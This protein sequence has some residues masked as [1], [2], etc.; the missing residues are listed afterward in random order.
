MIYE[1]L[2]AYLKDDVKAEDFAK[3]ATAIFTKW[4]ETEAGKGFLTDEAVKKLYQ[5]EIDR[6][7]SKALETFQAKTMPE[8]IKEAVEA[9]IK[10]LNPEETPEQ[11]RIRELEER[12]KQLEKQ[13]QRERLK[14]YA[15]KLLTEKKLDALTGNIDIFIVGD[16][17]EEVRAK[18]EAVETAIN[19]IVEKA[20][21]E[22]I[23]SYNGSGGNNGSGGGFNIDP[24]EKN[25]YK[26]GES[27]NITEQMKIEAE[28]P[29]K[30]KYLK[31]LAEKGG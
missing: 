27:W 8:K 22:K 4:L 23:P 10:E 29:E 21:K 12:Q 28:D 5:P 30:A 6:Q 18:I 13:N 20:I 24:N 26:R 1:A 19:P 3:D 9:K 7:V 11:K 25:P 14:N 16:T 17:E 2:K 31:E 15:L